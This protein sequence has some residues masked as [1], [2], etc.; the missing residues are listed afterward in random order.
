M[1]KLILINMLKLLLIG[2]FFISVFVFVKDEMI[3]MGDF[4][5]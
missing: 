5:M 3:E 4:K 1:R 2:L